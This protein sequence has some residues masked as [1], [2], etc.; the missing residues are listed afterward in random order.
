MGG[1]H[2]LLAL[3]LKR[4]FYASWKWIQCISQSSA[5]RWHWPKLAPRQETRR[6]D[7]LILV[8][9]IKTLNIAGEGYSKIRPEPAL[10]RPG[11]LTVEVP[12]FDACRRGNTCQRLHRIFCARHTVR[13]D[14]ILES[15][16]TRRPRHAQALFKSQKVGTVGLNSAT[17]QSL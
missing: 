12:R 8:K 5:P 9:C 2:Y 16:P 3:T 15:A 4:C 1:L 14:L 17:L 10:M 6:S 13:Y 11:P 7:P